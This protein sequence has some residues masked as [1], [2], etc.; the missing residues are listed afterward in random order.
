MGLWI[1]VETPQ[2]L[3][4]FHVLRRDEATLRAIITRHVAPGTTVW[5][6][7]W[8]AY[9]NI[10]HWPG[11]NYVHQTVKHQ[12]NFINPNTGA[13]TQRIEVDWGHVKTQ[14]V[15]SLTLLPGHLAEYWFK[16]EHR[17]TPFNAI[18]T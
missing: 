5:S 15:T 8:A 17:A 4:M 11:F 13:H 9:R 6:D 16:K 14:L 18:V 12:V 10:Q 3:R 1:S 2:A 7:E